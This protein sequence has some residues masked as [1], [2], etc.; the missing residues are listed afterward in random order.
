MSLCAQRVQ[1]H[2]DA[3]KASGLKQVQIRI[4]NTRSFSFA[5]ECRRQSLSL[6]N[7]PHEAE[8]NDW[9]SNAVDTE[10]WE[11]CIVVRYVQH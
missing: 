10:G 3:I 7:D 4:P 1:R 9:L 6:W 5:Q 11:K 2:R 8:V